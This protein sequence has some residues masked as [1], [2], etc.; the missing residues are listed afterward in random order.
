MNILQYDVAGRSRDI[1]SGADMK[2]RLQPGKKK[3]LFT[4][5]YFL[6]T[7]WR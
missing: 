1:L 5:F 4:S 2:G 3:I 6:G 7:D